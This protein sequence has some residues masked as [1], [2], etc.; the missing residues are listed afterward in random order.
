MA[1]PE[2]KK[3]RVTFLWADEAAVD[4]DFKLGYSKALV[5]WANAFYGRFGFAL[6]VRPA[7]GTKK[8]EAYKYALVKTD[9]YEP[10]TES[11]ELFMLRYRVT[12]G[13]KE[14]VRKKLDEEAERAELE[15]K[16]KQAALGAAISLA[17][18]N[19]APDRATQLARLRGPFDEW[20][21]ARDVAKA[22]RK[23]ER[24]EKAKIDAWVLK[25]AKQRWRKDFD[26]RLRGQLGQKFIESMPPGPLHPVKLP[27]ENRDIFD[28]SRLKVI[29]CRFRTAPDR[30]VL[31]ATQPRGA[32]VKPAPY[33]SF[34]GEFLWYGTYI[35]LNLF[36]R[37]GIT[38]AHEIVHAAGRDH[39]YEFDRLKGLRE[40]FSEIRIDPQ[41]GIPQLPSLVEHITGVYAGFY[42]GPPDDIINY[43]SIGQEDPSKVT[44]YPEDKARL[45]KAPF[46]ADPPAQP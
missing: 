24:D 29:F 35:I 18:T 33:N 4:E 14:D 20:L 39:I 2:K 44:L 38:L 37:D 32:T 11:G 43:N 13:A 27:T 25:Y 31:R 22:K 40:Y 28:G 45:E 6:D 36:R 42:D 7:L 3:I 1:E 5:D 21:Q 8:Q 23:L 10:D 19:P 34:N 41:T 16:A 46:V 15:K 12:K 9:G 30:L 26:T 17:I